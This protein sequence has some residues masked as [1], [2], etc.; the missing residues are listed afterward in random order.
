MVT[1]ID[2]G[3]DEVNYFNDE[4]RTLRCHSRGFHE[5]VLFPL[6]LTTFHTVSAIMDREALYHE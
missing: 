2:D 4:R 1:R 5:R 6:T 3:I